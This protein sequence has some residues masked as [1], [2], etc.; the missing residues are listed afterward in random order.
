SFSNPIPPS[1]VSYL[2]SEFGSWQVEKIR[3][4]GKEQVEMFI[5]GF[6]KFSSVF[7]VCGILMSSAF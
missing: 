5:A 2:N 7:L 6:F 3:I 1:V 4:S